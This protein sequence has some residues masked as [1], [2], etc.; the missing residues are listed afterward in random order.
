MNMITMI[1]TL[2][3]LLV[4][5]VGGVVLF[6]QAFNKS[7][8]W[9]LACFFINPV[10]L[11]FIALHWDE[12]KGTFFIQVIGFSVLLIGLGLHQYIHI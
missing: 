11:L 6:L 2:I 12:T 8:A 9:G 3:G 1:I 7:I 4:F 10:C 5:I